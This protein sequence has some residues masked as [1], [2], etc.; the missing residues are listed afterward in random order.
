[1]FNFP[2]RMDQRTKEDHTYKSW[3]LWTLLFPGSIQGPE[4][5][6]DPDRKI[7]W[8]VCTSTPYLPPPTKC[9]CFGTYFLE[10]W[11]NWWKQ[12]HILGSC[13]FSPKVC[14]VIWQIYVSFFQKVSSASSKWHF[15]AVF[16]L[17][18]CRLCHNKPNLPFP[19]TPN[20][21]L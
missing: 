8:C 10:K 15:S 14:M 21:Q 11:L 1:M 12:K 13:T 5:F 9:R 17:R 6:S 4:I 16:V 19:S 18:R 7:R 2:F 20:K 3:I